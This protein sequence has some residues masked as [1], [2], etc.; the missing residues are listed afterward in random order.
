[1]GFKEE[2]GRT[3]V[4]SVREISPRRET[5]KHFSPPMPMTAPFPFSCSMIPYPAAAPRSVG[6]PRKAALPDGERKAVLEL[7]KRKFSIL[8]DREL[9]PYPVDKQLAFGLA[10]GR[11]VLEKYLSGA[12]EEKTMVLTDTLGVV[13]STGKVV[14]VS[15]GGSAFAT[16][17]VPGMVLKSIN[18]KRFERAE[19][20]D[21]AFTSEP[22][23][24]TVTYTFP[25]L[26]QNGPI[27]LTQPVTLQ[28]ATRQV[29]LADAP[30]WG[31]NNPQKKTSDALAS[32]ALRRSNSLKRRQEPILLPRG[33][34]GIALEGGPGRMAK[35]EVSEHI[36][37]IHEAN[38]AG[39]APID[40]L[41]EIADEK[42]VAELLAKVYSSKRD[43][44]L[45]KDDYKELCND[46]G[47]PDLFDDAKDDQN[48]VTS[49]GLKSTAHKMLKDHEKIL[50]DIALSKN[51]TKMSMQ[52]SDAV[53][54][55]KMNA[56]TTTAPISSGQLDAATRKIVEL[57]RSKPGTVL[58][59]LLENITAPE[60]TDKLL[61]KAEAARELFRHKAKL[62]PNKTPMDLLVMLL[63]TMAGPDIDALYQYPDVPA[64]GGKEWQEYTS[65]KTP[66]RNGA[67]FS[68]VNGLMRSIGTGSCDWGALRKWVKTVCTLHSLCIQSE[69]THQ[70][71]LSR[72]LAGLPKS[73]VD[74]HEVLK[75]GDELNW[76]A[77]SSCAVDP[78]VAHNYIKGQAANATKT[79]GGSIFFSVTGAFAALPLQ[80]ISKYPKE[81]EVLIPPL[82]TFQVQE[83]SKKDGYLKLSLTWKSAQAMDELIAQVVK[84]S[85]IASARLKARSDEKDEA[86]RK[87]FGS[88]E[89]ASLPPWLPTSPRPGFGASPILS[90]QTSPPGASVAGVK[91]DVPPLHL[92]HQS[93][94][95]TPCHNALSPT[96]PQRNRQ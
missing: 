50:R 56:M 95:P 34:R 51:A 42:D 74:A 93:W 27:V 8:D 55:D 73:V 70:H 53:C 17:A 7:L 46:I 12:V 58:D 11:A 94:H 64:Y 25:R 77:P 36:F 66:I 20:V 40:V 16:G 6:V 92:D 5:S 81:A 15:P 24:M 2:N 19:E 68:A 87:L 67:L 32:P 90:A 69:N 57:Y 78:D 49:R 52:T 10:E 61:V 47:M 86:A 59:E 9:H 45:G 75:P 37:W 38:I 96:S 44:K 63:Y 79:G 14:Q 33:T 65:K 39:L 62:Y 76:T 29:S 41:G 71:D 89:T 83:R 28:R 88:P 3:M 21:K 4:Q 48:V 54:A 84:D 1:M 13:V 91:K 22:C 60:G 31:A 43:G 23:P 72:G 82:S 35:V 85:K 80:N 30:P 26:M 18:Q